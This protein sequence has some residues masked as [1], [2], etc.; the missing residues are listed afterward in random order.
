MN[1]TLRRPLLTAA[2]ALLALL[3]PCPGSAEEVDV[4]YM[5]TTTADNKSYITKLDGSF[6]LPMVYLAEG[7]IKVNYRSIDLA[8]I[9]GIRFEMRTETVSGIEE[10]ASDSGNRTAGGK[11]FTLDGRQVD[12]GA[13]QLPKGLYIIGK[14]KVVIR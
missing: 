3:T 1:I 12:S 6:R 14:R 13:G 7:K 4:F 11:V 10:A 2:G 9:E 8:D 5:T